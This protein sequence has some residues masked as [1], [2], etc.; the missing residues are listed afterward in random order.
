MIIILNLIPSNFRIRVARAEKGQKAVVHDARNKGKNTSV[1]VCVNKEIG[2]VAF[3]YKEGS[4]N[5][6]VFISF[7]NIMLSSVYEMNIPN[8]ILVF[9]NTRIHQKDQIDQ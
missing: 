3:D 8:P 1:V 4:I 2:M 5:S 6:E 9:D 7:F